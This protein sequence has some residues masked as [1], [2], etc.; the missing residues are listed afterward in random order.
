MRILPAFACLIVLGASPTSAQKDEPKR[1]KLA[2]G[3]DTNDA[4]AYFDFAVEQLAKEPQRAADAFYWA[5]RIEPTWADAY[6]ARRLALMMKDVNRSWRYSSGD[7]KAMEEAR[8]LDSL[9]YRAMTINPFIER[10]LDRQYL[11]AV[12]DDI[13]FRA[14]RGPRGN[15]GQMR[16][17][18]DE[19]VRAWPPA[20]R[21]WLA[22][23]DGWYAG[24]A[25]LYTQA[26]KADTA[27]WQL[28][29]DRGR[30]Y[31]SMNVLD[32]AR[33]DFTNAIEKIRK[34]ET[35]ERVI[36]YESR[37]LLEH[38]LGAVYQ[39]QG[40][41]EA[42]KEAFGRALQED[43]SYYPAHLQLAL[44]AL[45]A[46]DTTVGLAELELATQL[47][48]DDA[49]AQFV[50]GYTLLL[51]GRAADAE[52]HVKRAMEL[53]P[54]YALP[55]FIYARLLE[56]ADFGEEAVVAYKE[57]LAVAARSHPRRVEAETRLAAL[58]K[59]APQELR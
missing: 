9:M 12:L 1:P 29:A 13:A 22:F 41:I 38:S 36:I 4:H 40:N 26:I 30:V 28:L 21:A 25:S 27:N 20:M 33:M 52:K 5:S 7:R 17:M 47:R 48:D 6:Y 56:S 58:S 51:V 57:F 24:A 10:T 14:A 45:D 8:M 19:F 43:L 39:R 44:I 53:D 54:Y 3:A 32:S 59:P 23:S 18:L 15:S 55:K 16:D 2:A 42:A 37:A 34:A 11:N 49:G 35:K 46:K 50:H 31:F